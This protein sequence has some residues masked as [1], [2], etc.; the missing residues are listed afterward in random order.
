[1]KSKWET[2]TLGEIGDIFS[3]NS[4]NEKV[5]KTKYMNLKE[6]TPYVATK[7]ISY[8]N[9]INY[10]NGVKIPKTELD[11]FRIAH[12]NSVFICA[13]GGSAGRKLAFNTQ[14]VCFVNKLFVFE[15]EKLIQPKFIYYFYQSV[16][17]R[18]KRFQSV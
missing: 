14:D 12:K 5:K 15:A 10:N 4:I 13:E 6:G 17:S 9:E 18:Q 3:G 11:K 8:E 7:D 16:N 2:K 1:M